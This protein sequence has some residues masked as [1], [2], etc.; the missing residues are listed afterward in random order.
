VTAIPLADALDEQSFGGKAVQLGAAI[1]AGLPVPDGLALSVEVVEAVGRGDRA[2]RGRVD[3]LCDGLGGPVAVRSS[4]IG[5]DSA[6]ASFAGQHATFLNVTGG[7]VADAVEGVWRSG[8]SEAALAYRRRV[9]GDETLRMGVVVQRLVAA[10]VA[11]VLFTRDPV[12]AADQ[13]V[14]EA[15]WGLGEAIVQGLVVPDQFR[16]S[17]DGAVLARRAGYKPLAVGL[18]DGGTTERP[19]DGP[20]VEALCL[21][22]AM[23]R[24]LADLATRCEE[25]FGAGPHDIEWCFESDELFLLQRRAITAMG[26]SP[27]SP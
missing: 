21:D 15:S 10:D 26:A 17:R 23:L 22:D 25:A 24:A 12:T 4:A 3:R 13:M 20:L 2:T 8:S 14:I 16:V 9:G 6:A 27:G 7:T 11:G 19:V 18:R 5:E 1:R